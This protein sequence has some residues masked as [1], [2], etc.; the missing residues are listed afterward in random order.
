MKNAQTHKKPQTKKPQ[1]N[2]QAF[3]LPSSEKGVG[4]GEGFRIRLLPPVAMETNLSLFLPSGTENE[5]LAQRKK[6]ACTVRIV[7]RPLRQL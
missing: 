4:V 1:P 6:R 3:I 2:F 7:V 5:I